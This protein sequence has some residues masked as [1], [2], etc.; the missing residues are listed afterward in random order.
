MSGVCHGVITHTIVCRGAGKDC[1]NHLWHHSAMGGSRLN[2]C[3]K[4]ESEG[5]AMVAET[6]SLFSINTHTHTPTHG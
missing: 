2:F 3:A 6:V 1:R 4:I 5:S